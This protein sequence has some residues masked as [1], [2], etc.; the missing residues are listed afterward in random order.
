MLAALAGLPE[1]TGWAIAQELSPAPNCT[2][3]GDLALTAGDVAALAALR[4]DLTTAER[5]VAQV[6]ATPP[7]TGGTDHDQFV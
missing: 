2:L 6:A 7:V 5:W 3:L 4:Q 1:D